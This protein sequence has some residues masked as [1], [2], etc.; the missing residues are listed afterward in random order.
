MANVEMLGN[1]QFPTYDGFVDEEIG[2]RIR[3]RLNLV[4]PN[5]NQKQLAE[6]LEMTPDALSRSLSGKRAFT[7]VELVRAADVLGTSAHW[8]VTGEPDPFAV[9]VSGRQTFDRVAKSHKP[10]DWSAADETISN[11]ALAYLQVYPVPVSKTALPVPRSAGETRAALKAAFD[12][13]FVRHLS[14]ATE[15][16]FGVDV[17]RV[18]NLPHAIAMEVGGRYAILV[19]ETG[20]WFF[21]NW[22]IGHELGHIALGQLSDLG[23][24][25][26]DDPDAERAANAFAAEL[27]MPE[28]DVRAVSWTSMDAARLARFLWSTG[29]STQAL[30]TRLSAL[31]VSRSAEVDSELKKATQAVIR[32]SQILS[33]EPGDRISE[34]IQQASSRRFPDHLI[35]AHTD[36]VAEG[37]IG[38]SVLAWML[39]VPTEQLNEQLAPPLETNVDVDELAR[40]L[41]LVDPSS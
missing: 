7:A 36:A 10:V 5:L 8:F 20:N 24:D 11:L 38:A 25:A 4:K 19:S 14:E 3:E 22:S 33:S 31:G 18:G 40:E 30:D 23:T 2:I 12:G 6:K 16:A 15:K 17:I 39:G 34:R 1:S 29:V 13:D 41:G 28:S 35:S 21:E 27:L 9:K 37:K 32:H 26:C